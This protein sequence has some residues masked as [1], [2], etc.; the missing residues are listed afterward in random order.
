MKSGTLK[1][2]IKPLY[3]TRR[4]WCRY[5]F[6]VL[7]KLCCIVGR[8]NANTKC[9]FREQC[10][11]LVKCKQTP[12]SKNNIILNDYSHSLHTLHTNYRTR[13]SNNSLLMRLFAMTVEFFKT[14][15]LCSQ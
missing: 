13:N 3:F 6:S 7:S 8:N 4:V 15:F 10:R 2:N 12:Q 5:D 1:T 14:Y 11:G 9:G